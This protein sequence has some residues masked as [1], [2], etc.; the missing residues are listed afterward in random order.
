MSDIEKKRVCVCVCGFGFDGGGPLLLLLLVDALL[1]RDGDG[2]Y[3][4]SLT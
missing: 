3:L 1:C 2:V 4:Q